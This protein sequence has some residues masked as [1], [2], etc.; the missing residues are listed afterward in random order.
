MPV[1]GFPPQVGMPDPGL[2]GMGRHLNSNGSIHGTVDDPVQ[3]PANQD[4]GVGRND[5]WNFDME[6]ETGIMMERPAWMRS[7]LIVS[8]PAKDKLVVVLCCWW[9][10]ARSSTL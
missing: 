5:R 4:T 6:I 7:G 9:S 1:A 10:P 8:R 2:T 3:N